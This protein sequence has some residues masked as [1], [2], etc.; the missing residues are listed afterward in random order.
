MKRTLILLA[1]GMVIFG[2]S[3]CTLSQLRAPTPLP[4][5]VALSTPTAP[6]ATQPPAASPTPIQP[7]ATPLPVQPSATTALV[8]STS[9]PGSAAT[10]ASGVILPGQPSG[11]YGVINVAAGDVLNVHSAAGTGSSI[12]GTFAASANNIMRTGPSTTLDNALWVQVFSP[13][14]GNGWVNAAYLTEYVAPAAFCADGRVNSLL[15]SF[16]NAVMA[17]N[18]TALYPLVSPRHGMT[19]RL[20]RNGNPVNFDQSHAEWIFSSS[21]AHDWGAAPGSGQ[22]TVGSIHAVVVPKWLDVFKAP[23]PGYT[24]SCNVPQTGGASYDT[25]WPKIY[26]NIN[27]YSI[28]KPGPAGNENS[29]RTLLIGVEYVQNQPYIFSVTQLEWEP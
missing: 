17:S 6:A 24:L 16:G 9:V 23:A 22:A 11:P 12:I 4:S 28:Y 25:S 13:K 10:P 14:G 19:V 15:N 3:A 20:W 29:W 26:A 21:Y 27:F 18:G 7:S 1:A 5:P 2:L 8:I